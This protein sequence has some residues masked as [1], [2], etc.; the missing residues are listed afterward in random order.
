MLVAF[1]WWRWW[2]W[3]DDDDNYY[4]DTEKMFSTHQDRAGQV[5]LDLLFVH[6]ADDEQEEVEDDA[7][8]L[9][10]GRTFSAFLEI[11]LRQKKV[12]AWTW[13]SIMLVKK[14]QRKNRAVNISQAADEDDD[15]I[16]CS[17]CTVPFQKVVSFTEEKNLLF[18]TT[19]LSW[20][21][22]FALWIL[23]HVHV[24]NSFF[25]SFHFQ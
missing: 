21:S 13:M 22:I 15:H 10:G 23:F 12:K 5:T 1:E 7:L 4:R 24:S 25:L 20:C 11:S 19:Y 17:C 3:Y 16:L 18:A 9:S 8:G 2:W 6:W 14:E